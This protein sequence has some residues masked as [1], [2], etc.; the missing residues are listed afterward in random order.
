MSVIDTTLPGSAN[1]D[2][3]SLERH[4]HTHSDTHAPS[5]T[6]THA[7]RCPRPGSPIARKARVVVHHEEQGWYLLCNGVV[8]FDDGGAIL[9]NG[10]VVSPAPQAA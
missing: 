8:L 5:H 3:W 6:C 7:P 9:P 2:T 10:R 4:S 1:P